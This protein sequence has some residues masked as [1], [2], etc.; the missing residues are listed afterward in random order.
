MNIEIDVIGERPNPLVVIGEIGVV[1]DPDNMPITIAQRIY[2]GKPGIF[3]YERLVEWL[4]V[5]ELVSLREALDF[6]IDHRIEV[7]GDDVCIDCAHPTRGDYS[8]WPEP[9]SCMPCDTPWKDIY[10]AH[11]WEGACP[12]C[13]PNR[14]CPVH[15]EE[16]GY[17]HVCGRFGD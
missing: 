17:V 2:G 13:S 14:P 7:V 6:I 9:V 11:G 12:D 5:D 16:T 3:R 8:D 1:D 4:D 10:Y 15:A